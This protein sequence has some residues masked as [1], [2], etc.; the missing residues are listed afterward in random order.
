MA[1]TSALLGFEFFCALPVFIIVN[2]NDQFYLL[3]F[4]SKKIK[5][6]QFVKAIFYGFFFLAREKKRIPIIYIHIWPTV[7]YF[8]P[9]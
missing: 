2:I 7:V 3:G 1:M 4:L 5:L 6:L 8:R 9:I